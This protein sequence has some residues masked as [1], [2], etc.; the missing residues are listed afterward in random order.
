MLKHE[1]AGR[2]D[3]PGEDVECMRVSWR[4]SPNKSISLESAV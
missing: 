1:S 4:E 2:Q 3:S